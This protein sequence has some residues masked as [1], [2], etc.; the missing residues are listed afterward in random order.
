MANDESTPK[1]PRRG[2]PPEG[3]S[4]RRWRSTTSPRK[5]RLRPP[6]TRTPEPDPRP[7]VPAVAEAAP[8][9]AEAP[10][11]ARRRPRRSAGRAPP[12]APPSE[13][14]PRP[15]RPQG[16]GHHQ[17]GPGGQVAGDPRRRH[18]EEAG[19]GL[20]DPARAG[21][22]GR[23]H[24]LRGRARDPARRLRLPARPRVLL[25]AGA[26][27]HLRLAVADPQVRPAHRRHHQRPDP[28]AQGGRALLRP[29]QGGRGQLRAAGPV[30]G[31]DLL[32][33]PDPALPA[34]PHPAGDDARQPRP[35]ACSTSWP[36]WARASAR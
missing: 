21:G 36:R 33:Q 7:P 29:H 15:R 6:P 31:E 16:D 19:A 8:A 25:P 24:L 26:G 32:R 4:G 28:P 20:P 22:E 30:E 10:A 1:P 27:R 11:A 18:H 34:G 3:R 13:K 14:R 17:A 5:R 2:R 23:P 9:P 35:P 12:P